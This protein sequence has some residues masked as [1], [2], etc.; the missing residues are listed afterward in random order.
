MYGIVQPDQMN[1]AVLFWY[2]V[3]SDDNVRYCKVAYTAQVTFYTFC[4]WYSTTGQDKHGRVVLVPCKKLR[5]CTVLW[6][7]S[8]NAVVKIVEKRFSGKF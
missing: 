4:V 7:S 3:K 2:L 1:M 6:Y 8:S 5:Y